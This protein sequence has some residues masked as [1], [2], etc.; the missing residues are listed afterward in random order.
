MYIYLLQTRHVDLPMMPLVSTV[1]YIQSYRCITITILYNN[2]FLFHK[3]LFHSRYIGNG[4][5]IWTDYFFQT[6]QDVNTFL[7][8][9]LY[10]LYFSFACFWLRIQIQFL[11]STIA[12]F[13]YIEIQY[14]FFLI[15]GYIFNIL[16]HYLQKWSESHVWPL[17][18]L[19]AIKLKWY[20]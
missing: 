15:K 10:W 2:F 1:Q 20:I 16:P 6:N 8:T 7:S 5:V 11:C 12:C 3:D 14:I 17:S 4:G 13:E 19:H 18:F 9:L